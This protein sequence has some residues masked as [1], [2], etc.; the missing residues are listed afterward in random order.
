MDAERRVKL[1]C[2][3]TRQSLVAAWSAAAHPTRQSGFDEVVELRW[4]SD[5]DSCS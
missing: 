1:G 3:H 5:S 2:K 4:Y